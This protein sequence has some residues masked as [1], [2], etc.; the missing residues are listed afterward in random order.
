P[1][2]R[3][4]TGGPPC[5]LRRGACS[6]PRYPWLPGYRG[7]RG[8]SKKTAE[9]RA[10]SGSQRGPRPC[11]IASVT[12]HRSALLALLS[13]LLLATG[14][15]CG[16]PPPNGSCTSDAECGRGSRC[17]DGRCE[18]DHEPGD[19]AAPTCE[20]ACADGELCVHGTCARDSGP[21]AE[22]A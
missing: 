3:T 18:V 2:G 1:R 19:A 6:D 22:N 13:L 12:S 21:C 8:T 20:P 17:I 14:C 9:G 7:R 5:C 16:P 4:R 10:C 11:T 15:E